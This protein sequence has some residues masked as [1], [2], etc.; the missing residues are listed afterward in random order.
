MTC[1]N[2]GYSFSPAVF[3]AS[4]KDRATDLQKIPGALQG[5]NRVK[6]LCHI[7]AND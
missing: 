6:L 2:S 1:R 5:P 7:L 3:Q 4:Q